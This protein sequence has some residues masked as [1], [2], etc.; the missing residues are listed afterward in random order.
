[1]APS[2]SKHRKKR[3]LDNEKKANS[4]SAAEKQTAL[5]SAV[6]ETE[7]TG[8]PEVRAI[9][10]NVPRPE[11]K[12]K[13]FTR[14]VCGMDSYS[15]ADLELHFNMKTSRFWKWSL[16]FLNK[17]DKQIMR[18]CV[19]LTPGQLMQTLQDSGVKSID[20]ASMS[21][22]DMANLMMALQKQMAVEDSVT[23]ATITEQA[24]LNVA[25]T[26]EPSVELVT[27]LVH[28]SNDVVE[29]VQASQQ[30]ET[31]AN[32]MDID[33]SDDV[34]MD[35]DVEEEHDFPQTHLSGPWDSVTEA[36]IAQNEV[37]SETVQ[38][39]EEPTATEQPQVKIVTPEDMLRMKGHTNAAWPSFRVE[40]VAA[41]FRTWCEDNS[42]LIK[43]KMEYD[44]GTTGFAMYVADRLPVSLLSTWGDIAEN[45]LTWLKA[46]KTVDPL[47][48]VTRQDLA[49]FFTQPRVPSAIMAVLMQYDAGMIDDPVQWPR[50]T[51]KTVSD[52]FRRLQGA[53]TAVVQQDILKHLANVQPDHQQWIDA[54][55]TRFEF[56]RKSDH[57]P[58]VDAKFKGFI[59]V[60]CDVWDRGAAFKTPAQTKK[61]APAQHTKT[62]SAQMPPPAQRATQPIAE[63]RPYADVVQDTTDKTSGPPSEQVKSRMRQ[64]FGPNVEQLLALYGGNFQDVEPLLMKQAARKD[65][66]EQ[67]LGALPAHPPACTNAT[68]APKNVRFQ[69]TKVNNVQQQKE[70]S[71]EPVDIIDR[72]VE[73]AGSRE[74]GESERIMAELV[75]MQ[76]LVRAFTTTQ[77]QNNNTTPPILD[78][79][80]LH[81][82]VSNP[83]SERGRRRRRRRSPSSSSSESASSRSRS[84]S[85]SNKTTSRRT[86]SQERKYN[87]SSGI[88]D[89]TCPLPVNSSPD[90]VGDYM[91]Y[92]LPMSHT[93]KYKTFMNNCKPYVENGSVTWEKWT[94]DV[95]TQCKSLNFTYDQTWRLATTLLPEN[96]QGIVS[97]EVKRGDF[98]GLCYTKWKLLAGKAA[99]RMEPVALAIKEMQA[100]QFTKHEPVD[101]FIHRFQEVSNR[102]MAPSC[103]MAQSL[104][105][106]QILTYMN[107]I[108]SN[109]HGNNP[110]WLVTTWNAKFGEVHDETKQKCMV[111]S[112]TGC[113]LSDAQKD[114]IIDRSI[115]IMSDWAVRTAN[116]RNETLSELNALTTLEVTATPRTRQE[117]PRNSG[118]AALVGVTTT[119]S[120]GRGRGNGGGRGRSGGTWTA[121]RGST[122]VNAVIQETA[123]SVQPP[124][125]NEDRPV[126]AS[127]YGLSYQEPPPF[128]PTWLDLPI[129]PRTLGKTT[130]KGQAMA[131]YG[132]C[133]FDEAAKAKISWTCTG[134][135]KGY[136]ECWSISDCTGIQPDMKDKIFK[137]HKYLS[138]TRSNKCFENKKKT[139]EAAKPPQQPV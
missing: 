9:S 67:D 28:S 101:E 83:R 29:L 13:Q 16:Q 73:N 64:T 61:P 49:K 17:R 107:G 31:E 94:F 77:S 89:T 52:I 135:K 118:A 110:H 54:Q 10:I 104:R 46:N 106:L 26:D 124:A 120:R 92:G 41:L 113:S 30:R 139:A 35:D 125:E 84:R 132:I 47:D 60:E 12:R 90:A 103:G 62:T 24:T 34:E 59:H 111:L 100:L 5:D 63:K 86:A 20:F 112:D 75:R 119:S 69:G 121:G 44:S 123:N 99:V 138:V 129:P 21:K 40:D 18:D 126:R 105:P 25:A 81:S 4:G 42:T 74:L 65:E 38:A 95:R 130:T 2:S 36:D 131:E 96:I 32:E 22:A 43:N 85:R 71:N 136:K 45:Y 116:T 76:G 58:E 98:K 3:N 66:I 108:F 15:I 53:S 70:D 72:V 117:T 134:C 87:E 39:E 27:P 128:D 1:M 48:V 50:M 11:I 115:D 57:L 109:R 80:L 14:F 114:D 56:R 68:V 97:K 7:I 37:P 88:V 23:P 133:T 122:L 8:Q 33:M 93:S 79:G 78:T 102:A 55:W 127:T 19:G 137:R 6:G 82:P 51:G 91:R